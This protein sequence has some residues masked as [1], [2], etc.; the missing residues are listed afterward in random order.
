[1]AT[2][3]CF[4]GKAPP[5]QGRDSHQSFWLAYALAQ[6]GHE[7]DLVTNAND[8]EYE[9]R[10]FDPGGWHPLDELV[11]NAT[12]ALRIHHTSLPP[13]LGHVPWGEP[14]VTKLAASA[15][16][17]IRERDSDLIFGYNL[18]PYSIAAYLASK[19][20]GVPYGIHHARDDFLRLFR[21]PRL[22]RAYVEILRNAEYLFA[23]SASY[24]DFLRLGIEPDKLY[25]TVPTLLPTRFFQPEAPQLDINQLLTVACQRLPTET[26][27]GALHRLA[28]KH[29]DR[30]IPT[31]G[32]YGGIGEETGSLDLVHALG[33]LRASGEEFNFLAVVQGHAPVIRAFI[34]AV[35]ACGLEDVTWLLPVLPQ[36]QMPRFIRS[37]SAVCFLER[38][39]PVRSHRSPAPSEVFACGTCLILSR[40]VAVK[41]PYRTRILSGWNAL[42][43]DPANIDRLAATL[44]L[45]LDSGLSREIGRNGFQD[46]GSKF[47]DFDTLASR[48]AVLFEK[49]ADDVVERRATMSFAELQQCLCR[50]YTDDSFRK[51]HAIQS[52]ATF[53]EYRLTD[54][55]KATIKSIDRKMLSA[56]AQALESK[57][58]RRFQ[59]VYPLV[60]ALPDAVGVRYFKRYNQLHP[61]SPDDF[62]QDELV[63]FGAFVERCFQAESESA[64]YAANLARFERLC[65]EVVLTADANDRNRTGFH[66][67][68]DLSPQSSMRPYLRGGVRT[69]GFEYDIM[70]LGEQLRQGR[71]PLTPRRSPVHFAFAPH[72]LKILKVSA[73]T[74]SL[75]DSCGQSKT[76]AELVTEMERLHRQSNLGAETVKMLTYL[77]RS[78]LIAFDIE[79]ASRAGV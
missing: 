33:Q 20:T 50:L 31:L 27:D 61:A 19:W 44:R 30:S 7:V 49:I 60:F 14:Q 57:R 42:L 1:M 41:L 64:P 4:I 68:D 67:V 15:V 74:A 73:A 46:I 26:Y 70:E 23:G 45:A 16:K 71:E 55:E 6:Q 18:E 38:G 43:V 3:F 2:R 39:F 5:I 47:D 29:F 8:V 40:Q 35:K 9:H 63:K 32:I 77:E 24:S 34:E 51:L 72:P 13:K 28:A 78:E 25:G 53:E 66:V 37:C 54:Q 11:D 58:M 48:I 10:T 62:N 79:G 22:R 76:V 65:V 36:W 69:A 75:L 56:F 59:L 21:D 52:E 17:I 12:G